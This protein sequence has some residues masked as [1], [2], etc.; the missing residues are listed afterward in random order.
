MQIVLGVSA[1]AA[2]YKACTLASRLTQEGFTV[3]VVLTPHAAQ[4][5]APRLFSALTGR[6]ALV[7]EFA[8]ESSEAMA[9][10]ALA[11]RAALLLV[12]PATAATIA[13]FAHAQADD[14]LSTLALALRPETPRWIAPA[15]NPR[16]FLHPGVQ[17]NLRTLAAQGWR[18]LEPEAGWL[19]CG[20]RG[21]GRML[22]P[23][24]I[25]ALVVAWRDAQASGR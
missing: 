24:Q 14:L 20:D 17:E 13:K 25:A 11:D 21:P 15:M 5:I 19:A 3:D 22:E 9:H 4:L 12:A 16:M 7:D 1:S 18:Q 8:A 6:P 23:E 10:I 2:C